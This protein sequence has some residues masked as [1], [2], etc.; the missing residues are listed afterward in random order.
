MKQLRCAWPLVLLLSLALALTGCQFLGQG[1]VMDEEEPVAPP[2]QPIV[3]LDFKDI[4][5]PSGL[6][7]DRDS[8]FVYQSKAMV[9]GVL[10]FT[11]ADSMPEIIGAFE[12][13]MGKDNW[14]LLSS[15]KYQKNILIYSKTGKICLVIANQPPGMNSVRIEIWV[16]PLKPEQ[17][18]SA[19]PSA[20]GRIKAGSIPLVKPAQPREEDLSGKD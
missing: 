14:T 7:L 9:T 1:E 4:Q 8:S 16:A 15:F 3:Y 11:S 20:L 17:E 2:P 19:A 18:I 10:T 5:I 12:E 6:E 13:N